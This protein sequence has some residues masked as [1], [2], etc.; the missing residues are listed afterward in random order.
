MIF[1][2]PSASAAG[3]TKKVA[4]NVVLLLG[5]C[6]GI[7]AGP[8]FL[9][10]ESDNHQSSQYLEHD[11]KPSDRGCGGLLIVDPYGEGEQEAEQGAERSRR[12]SDRQR[13]GRDCI[14]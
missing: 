5:Y 9:Q 14:W 1:S 10:D 8:F 6:A 2:L 11:R 7:I 4:T 12:R 13:S 3:Y